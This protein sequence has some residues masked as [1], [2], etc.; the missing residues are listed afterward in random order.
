M[1]T[2]LK[3]MNAKQKIMGQE[4]LSVDQAVE[5]R[6]IPGVLTLSDS[7]VMDHKAYEVEFWKTYERSLIMED[8]VYWIKKCEPHPIGNEESFEENL[9]KNGGP[10]HSS[11]ISFPH[12]YMSTQLELLVTSD[13]AVMTEHFSS[14]SCLPDHYHESEGKITLRLLCGKWIEPG[15]MYSDSQVHHFV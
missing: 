13:W 12:R 8:S 6:K 1:K 7:V 11:I 4:I 3:L 5:N 14:R 10:A 2:E 9:R 15:F